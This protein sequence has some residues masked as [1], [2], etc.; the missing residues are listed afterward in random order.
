MNKL[1]LLAR[2]DGRQL[3]G[4]HG[5]PLLR[6]LPFPVL[7]LIDQANAHY[8]DVAAT[9]VEVEIVRWSNLADVRARVER[10][11]AAAPLLG[12][13]V[14]DEK[15]VDFAAELRE[16]L[17]LPGMHQAASR[18]FRDKLTMKALLGAAG[19]R[20]PAHARCDDTAAVASLLAVHQRLVVKPV[21][22]LG[23]R[24]VVFIDSP[25][26]LAGWYAQQPQPAAYE[27][28]EY[29]D[30]VLYHLNAVVCDGKPLLTA[31]AIY[32]PGMANIDF[33]SGA[34]FV[35]VLVTD[36][37][38]NARLCA[39]SDRVVD[40]LG[41]RNGVTHLECFVKADNE[42]VFC[43]T[44]AR[45]GG[46]GIALMIEAQ[47]AVNFAR[48]LLLLEGGR[49]DLIRP[50][51]DGGRVAGL[52]GFRHP[53][54]VFVKRIAPRERFSEE[55][56]RHVYLPVGP[57]AFVVAATHCTDFIGLLIFSSR[58]RTEFEQKRVDL[59]RRFYAELETEPA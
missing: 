53:D 37:E 14:L 3:L 45:P 9:G 52:I 54:T 49:G 31:C 50:E 57:G 24:D 12:I 58:N 34:P 4:L 39:F 42:I 27:A 1:L 51:H 7:V 20:V 13:A 5:Q 18:R 21:D 41:M 35:S 47:F 17:G 40:V 33:A 48:A 29:I 2:G 59:Y 19:L 30:G 11:H 38:L 23:S 46:G 43:E 8:V 25:Q 55:W 36:A 44:A 15:T 22:G 56:I 6:D 26:G 32:L 28:E 10:H 16:A